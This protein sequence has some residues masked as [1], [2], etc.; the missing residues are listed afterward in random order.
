VSDRRG[1]ERLH[2]RLIGLGH[3]VNAPIGEIY[4]AFVVPQAQVPSLVFVD[5]WPVSVLLVA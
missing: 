2:D 5:E 4:D 3:L 1:I